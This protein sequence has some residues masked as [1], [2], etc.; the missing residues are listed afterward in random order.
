MATLV[1]DI[2]TVGE[3]W[4]ELD[5]L[6]QQTLT[7]WIDRT[8]RTEEERTARMQDVKEGLGFSPLTGSVVSVAVYDVEREQGAVYYSAG[9]EVVDERRAAFV[10]KVRSEAALLRDFWDGARSYDTFVT[11]NGR[12]FDVPF[13]LHRSVV[14]GVVPTC[15]L[16]RRR[17]LSQQRPP[18]HI[19]LQDELTFY[20][21]MYRRPSLHLFCRAYGI[22]SPKTEEV[23]GDAVA[24]LYQQGRYKEIAEYNVADVVATT[25]LYRRWDTYLR[26][27]G[28]AEEQPIEY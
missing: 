1:F 6:T 8:A 13:L 26:Q 21:A 9:T 23:S 3:R 24:E 10:Y 27:S 15:D 7:R 17:Y 19:D 11:F 14:H 2:E 20:G 18:Y 4:D 25:E 28:G 12:A 22:E 5:E 16:M